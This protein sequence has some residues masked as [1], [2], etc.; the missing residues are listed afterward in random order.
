[1]SQFENGPERLKTWFNEKVLKT[2]K[3]FFSTIKQKHSKF[4]ITENNQ[5]A[6]LPLNKRMFK[7]IHCDSFKELY[8][9]FFHIQNG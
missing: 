6:S 5:S 3:P 1:M 8:D 2:F 9:F 4:D 7:K